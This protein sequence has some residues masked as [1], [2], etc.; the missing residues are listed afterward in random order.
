MQLRPFSVT[1]H[2]VGSGLVIIDSLNR[3]ITPTGAAV[4]ALLAA[5]ETSWL[6]Y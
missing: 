1:F 3:A 2:L 5:A 6:V 4:G